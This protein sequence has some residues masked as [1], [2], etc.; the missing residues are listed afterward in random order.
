MRRFSAVLLAVVAAVSAEAAPV[1]L[2]ELPPGYTQ[3]EYIETAK[4]QQY[5]DTG[6]KPTTSTDVKFSGY[7]DF[8]KSNT[9]V[10]FCART[11]DKSYPSYALICDKTTEFRTPCLA[12]GTTNAKQTC[13]AL[14]QQADITYETEGSDYSYNGLGRRGPTPLVESLDFP[15]YVFAINEDGALLASSNYA[16]GMRVK[17]LKFFENGVCIRDFVPCVRDADGRLGLYD[18][19]DHDDEE[20]YEPFYMNANY[21]ATGEFS[22]GPTA[23]ASLTV[24]LSENGRASLAMFAALPGVQPLSAPGTIG[25]LSL[26]DTV[27][28]RAPTDVYEASPMLKCRIAGWRL[29]ETDFLG[30]E[31]L[32]DESDE[33]TL[34]YV[35]HDGVNARLEWKVV[36]ESTVTASAGA[37]KKQI[38]ITVPSA[39][40]DEGKVIT[41][42]AALVRLSTAIEGF[43]YADFMLEKGGDRMFKDE[44]GN[45]LASEVD[46]WDESGESLVW[47][48]VPYFSRT[49]VITLCYGNGAVSGLAASDAWADYGGVWHFGE[50]SGMAFDST[51]H[52]FDGVPTGEY[53]TSIVA[54]SGIVGK[55]RMQ[56]GG[57]KFP[58]SQNRGYMAIPDY[59]ELAY[60]DTFT[61]SLWAYTYVTGFGGLYPYL[62]LRSGGW[63]AVLPNTTSKLNIQGS[64]TS[65]S[66]T[67]PSLNNKWAYLTIAY[68][69]TSVDVYTN[70][71]FCM[72]GTTKIAK[73]VAKDL[74]IG[75]EG[76]AG[77]GYADLRCKY[78][79][80]R[81][82]GL[83]ATPEQVAADYATMTDAAFLFYGAAEDTPEDPVLT[84]PVVTWSEEDGFTVDCELTQGTA[85]ISIAYESASAA[86]TNSFAGGAVQTG[87]V[88]I[89]DVPTN[90]ADNTV[91]RVIVLGRTSSGVFRAEA[92]SGLYTGKITIEK[93]A[94]AIYADPGVFTVRRAEGT[95]STWL[96]IVVAYEVGG[97]SEPGADYKELPG[98]V[99]IEAGESAAMIPVSTLKVQTSETELEL[100]LAEGGSYAVSEEKTTAKIFVVTARDGLNLN[101]T[102]EGDGRDFNLRM[103]W[104]PQYAPESNDTVQVCAPSPGLSLAETKNTRVRNLYFTDE[105]EN[106]G[107]AALDF[108]GHTLDI[109]TTLYFQGADTALSNGLLKTPEI[110]FGGTYDGHDCTKA[111]VALSGITL[112]SAT[113]SVAS[114]ATYDLTITDS[115]VTNVPYAL[116]DG[117][118]L[119]LDHAYFYNT[120]WLYGSSKSNTTLR[121]TNCSTV[122]CY[123]AMQPKVKYSRIVIDG[124][125]RVVGKNRNNFFAADANACGNVFAISNSYYSGEM[126]VNGRDGTAYV[127]DSSVGNI[128]V[129]AVNGRLYITGTNAEV[130]GGSVTFSSTNGYV[131]LLDA[132]Q[133]G[134]VDP[135]GAFAF[136]AESAR[137]T[138]RLGK[139]GDVCSLS[140]LRTYTNSFDNA[141]VVEGGG[142][143]KFS[144][145]NEPNSNFA[146]NGQT[147]RWV[148]RDGT[149]T[150]NPLSF[151]ALP[152]SDGCAIE[153]ADDAA[154][155]TFT[156]TLS[157][158]NDDPC[159]GDAIFRFFPGATGFGGAAPM[160]VADTATIRSNVVFEVNVANVTEATPRKVPLVTFKKNPSWDLE[161]VLSK[162]RTVPAGFGKI[163]Y[164]DKTRTLVYHK[165]V[166]LMILVR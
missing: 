36:T 108:G 4:S 79:E 77:E 88:A 154:K 56:P 12:D 119:T 76:R 33:N 117:S 80:L 115:V 81:L 151:S 161:R 61:V 137:N 114:G 43:S 73:D 10:F 54:D 3:L 13:L 92:Q 107:T 91:Y 46:T 83:T 18:L 26:G 2:R 129:S 165:A 53:A 94:D 116:A 97:T 47:V 164:N 158:G 11:N 121:I 57:S 144:R 28:C 66:S 71:A 67:V 159:A 74:C 62:L 98:F 59:S 25:N 78:D 16:L 22:A 153:C 30:K 126:T 141:I 55:A 51:A 32:V 21:D 101:W 104:D 82:T 49:S 132:K 111:G 96:P 39:S 136:A 142:S 102:G 8:S 48:K 146:F 86:I 5:I 58:G 24:S 163:T 155:M 166:G 29:Y 40:V 95:D 42:F 139:C 72:T 60:G 20:A 64:G 128:G 150:V 87:P 134:K 15:I 70:G 19:A 93:T 123:Y 90:L 112:P 113:W 63:Q 89:R 131:S 34:D 44:S 156:S 99:T 120:G 41:N 17:A 23:K 160:T 148:I 109:V 127:H 69:G 125:S 100:T 130:R 65:F 75:Y 45:V 157:A 162:T 27:T 106:A 103:N 6:V 149:I 50:A 110:Q 138:F 35:C 122:E 105:D 1:V 85:E 133:P 14:S 145:A 124:N 84:T 152:E 7:L 140:I 68:R 9:K 118:S 147:N 38:A 135:N 31:V 52:G 37:Y 143:M